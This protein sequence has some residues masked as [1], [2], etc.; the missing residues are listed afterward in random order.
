MSDDSS[1]NSSPWQPDAVYHTIRKISLPQRT[2]NPP[3]P[4]MVFIHPDAR[5]SRNQ[6]LQQFS[7]LSRRP[8]QQ[9][10]LRFDS[11]H[12]VRLK[13]KR[14]LNDILK[15]LKD[16]LENSTSPRTHYL[17]VKDKALKYARTQEKNEN[18]IMSPR[19]RMLREFEKV[20]VNDGLTSHK[21]KPSSG[22][23][24]DHQDRMCQGFGAKGFN[25][26]I[27]HS[28]DSLLNPLKVYDDGKSHRS[29]QS[30]IS[31][32]RNPQQ[33]SPSIPHTLTLLEKN[34]HRTLGIPPQF[35]KGQFLNLNPFGFMPP[36]QWRLESTTST[37]SYRGPVPSM[38]HPRYDAPHFYSPA[39]L[40]PPSQAHL[41]EIKSFP[42]IRCS[43]SA[44]AINS[45]QGKSIPHG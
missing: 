34:G 27:N 28:I 32:D 25:K 18:S 44:L 39:S 36:S 14:N 31:N 17:G 5:K 12:K 29:P 37:S 6:F 11:P 33:S 8:N 15:Y 26:P 30:S 16:Q 41:S 42:P 4:F 2:Q 38:I 43:S 9:Y 20:Q 10:T 23:L 24:N 35:Q 7:K 1:V 40:P 13:S 19:K 21:K 45:Q 3:V 22:A